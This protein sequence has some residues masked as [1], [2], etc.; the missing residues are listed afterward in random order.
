MLKRI[1]SSALLIFV[2]VTLGTIVYQELQ[3]SRSRAINWGTGSA[4]YVIYFHA[5][6]RCTT[7]NNME[8]YTKA[9][10]KSD[11]EEEVAK[12]AIRWQTH[13]WQ[14][15]ENKSYVEKFSLIGNAV[16]LVGVEKSSYV[17]HQNLPE[18]WDYSH[19]KIKF[20]EYI[21]SSIRNFMKDPNV[22][23]EVSKS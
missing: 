1:V 18:I 17:R 13:N 4:T 12:R 19:D 2:A 6:K 7:C 9:V 3:V 15:P 20:K 22:G 5:N 23:K 8:A 11:F 16:Y 14:K 21:R 10:L